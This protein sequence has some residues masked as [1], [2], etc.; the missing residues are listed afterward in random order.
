MPL[1]MIPKVTREIGSFDF[2]Y[3]EYNNSTSYDASKL[4]KYRC[5]FCGETSKSKFKS[6]SHLL[7]EFMGNKS[8]FSF[9]ECDDCNNKFSTYENSLKNFGVLNAYLPIKGKKKFPRLTDSKNKTVTE[10]TDKNT[11]KTH[12]KD[13]NAVI[14]DG[15]MV[16]LKIASNNFKPLYVYKALTKMAISLLSDKDANDLSVV[17]DWLIE[18]DKFYDDE[19]RFDTQLWIFYLTDI[20]C[21]LMKPSAFLFKKKTQHDSPEYIFILHWGRY[22]FQIYIPFVPNDNF[23]YGKQEI[24][25]PVSYNLILKYGYECGDDMKVKFEQADINSLHTYTLETATYHKANGTLPLPI[26]KL[27]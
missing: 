13:S 27:D 17:K 19:S 1:S 16:K 14:Y 6:K 4:E 2:V 15:E 23:L 11:L 5:R 9:N 20:T 12:I 21:K 7:P 3:T 26:T 24:K 22:K 8:L 18:K 25:I 10:F